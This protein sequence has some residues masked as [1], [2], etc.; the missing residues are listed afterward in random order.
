MGE[1][2][3]TEEKGYLSNAE[4]DNKIHVHN[5]T[6]NYG[7]RLP[8]ATPVND[9]NNSTIVQNRKG[10][11][12]IVIQGDKIRDNLMVQW[13]GGGNVVVMKDGENITGNRIDAGFEEGLKHHLGKVVDLLTSPVRA[14]AEWPP[15][16]LENDTIVLPGKREDYTFKFNND[17]KRE[18]AIYSG[19]VDITHRATGATNNF[20]NYEYVVFGGIE[21]LSNR[22]DLNHLKAEEAAKATVEKTRAQITPASKTAPQQIPPAKGDDLHL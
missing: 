1:K 7:D 14:V 6:E 11:G 4:G 3:Y 21:N 9:A 10:G 16:L 15:K 13:H 12:A 8:G 2:T 20:A 22:V 17:A 18:F 5:I 19:T